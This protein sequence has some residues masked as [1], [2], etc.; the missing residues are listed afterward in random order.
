MG[1]RGGMS[2]LPARIVT[3]PDCAFLP[4]QTSQSRL[5]SF[6]SP[7]HY[8]TFRDRDS[9]PTS[10]FLPFNLT[11]LLFNIYRRVFHLLCFCCHL[12]GGV[13]LGFW[14]GL[15][16]FRS[17]LKACRGE[18]RRSSWECLLENCCCCC[19]GMGSLGRFARIVAAAGAVALTSFE[20][21]LMHSPRVVEGDSTTRCDRLRAAHAEGASEES[22]SEAVCQQGVKTQMKRGAAPRMA[23]QFDGLNFYETYIGASQRWIAWTEGGREGGKQLVPTL[24]ERTLCF[25][26]FIFTLIAAT[27]CER[28]TT[29]ARKGRNHT[30]WEELL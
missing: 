1:P 11:I 2:A 13:W 25:L 24:P 6:P 20:V 19:C 10:I 4:L 27:S 26:N 5:R 16:V 12:V 9:I 3:S 15:R 7:D 21:G 18:A 30:S 23:P 28:V 8:I 17:D 14:R 29:L 22:R